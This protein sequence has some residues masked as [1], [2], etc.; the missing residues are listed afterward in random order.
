MNIFLKQKTHIY[1][2][3]CICNIHIMYIYMI[4]VYKINDILVVTK[5]A[6][7]TFDYRRMDPLWVSETDATVRT[8]T[9]DACAL[10]KV[11]GLI[12]IPGENHGKT[13]NNHGQSWNKHE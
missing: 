11:D 13:M 9:T 1:V 8:A 3:I 10:S 2:Y 6:F 4:Y 7:P 12:S 5:H